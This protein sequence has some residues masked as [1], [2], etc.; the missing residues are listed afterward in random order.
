MAI[1]RWSPVSE[2]TNL[3]TAMDRLFGDIAEQGTGSSM[4]PALRLPVDVIETEKGYEIRAPI[5]GFRPE[6]VEVDVSDGV[7][8]I[9]AVR[10]DEREDKK[11]DYLRREVAYG[12]FRRMIVLP[13][14]VRAE[15][16]NAEFDNG[17]LVVEIPRTR[18][19]E[20]RRV[21]VGRSQRSKS[22]QSE[23]KSE[24]KSESQAK[25]ET[26]SKAGSR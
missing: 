11:G 18:K 23:S 16:I 12:E 3:H 14:D 26:A 22:S 15:E 19:P 20:P 5:A 1:S 9:R 24:S 13:P 17:M 2:L 8:S 7:L 4:L 21:Q 10:R 25:P 6:D